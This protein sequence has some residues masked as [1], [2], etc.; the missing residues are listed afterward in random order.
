M[1]QLLATLS[2]LMV[3]VML[4]N[5]CANDAGTTT[6]ALRIV[7]MSPTATEILFAVGAS[8]H[9]VAVDKSSD[10]P[11]EAP[12]S[13]L[14]GF[15]PNVE[16]IV[17]FD[18]TMV[19][20]ESSGDLQPALETLGI[21]VVVQAAAVSLEDTYTQIREVG[22]LTGLT[23][24]AEMLASDLKQQ[25]ETLVANAPDA[26]GLTY[27][28][29]LAPTLYSVTSTT[30]IGAVYELFGLRNVAD[31]AEGSSFGYPQLS[32]EFLVDADPDLIFI[33][34]T[35]CCGQ[36]AE[37]VASRPGW[38]QMTAVQNGNIIELDDSIASRWG[39]RIIHFVNAIAEALRN[40]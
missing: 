33:A 6:D 4:A 24:N 28:H 2:A 11:P 27:Y 17:A 30:F 16:A 39:P 9:V 19:Y 10:F 34:D 14:D 13:N 32:N 31:P 26:S 37:T 38:Q 22:R 12:T 35:I 40:L 23:E 18:P 21:E 1:K 25:I 5:A 20:L 15:S 7:S 8:D 29:E 36:S 3:S